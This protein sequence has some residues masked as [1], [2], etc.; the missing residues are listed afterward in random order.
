MRPFEYECLTHYQLMAMIEGY[1]AK[2]NRDL[3]QTRLI[4]SAFNGQDPRQI[5]PLPGDYDEVNIS[6][7]ES[8]YELAVKMGMREK[9]DLD[10]MKPN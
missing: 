9:W 1:N 4:I 6:T 2:V 5:I 7:P 3:A 8:S 10:N